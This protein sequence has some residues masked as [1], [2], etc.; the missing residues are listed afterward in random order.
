[1]WPRSSYIPC[2]QALRLRGGRRGF[3]HGM[4]P[5][6]TTV[7]NQS[8]PSLRTGLRLQPPL[9]ETFLRPNLYSRSLASHVFD[10][11]GLPGG[12]R[13]LHTFGMRVYLGL[14]TGI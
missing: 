13:V 5:G 12:L 3:K 9:S 8:L 2:P 7:Q 6:G 4:L 14:W 11:Q 10:A 1:M